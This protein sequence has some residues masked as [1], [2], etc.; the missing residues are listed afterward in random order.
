MPES[1]LYRTQVIQKVTLD[2]TSLL[3]MVSA[4]NGLT[5]NEMAYMVIKDTKGLI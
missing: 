4:V 5:K 2:F 3:F 1:D